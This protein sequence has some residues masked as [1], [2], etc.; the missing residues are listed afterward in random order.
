MSNSQGQLATAIEKA[1]FKLVGNVKEAAFD[2]SMQTCLRNNEHNLPQETMEALFSVYRNAVHTAFFDE[3]ETFM[4][5]IRVE[6][7]KFAEESA[8]ASKKTK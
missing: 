2:A 4:Q 6:L 7:D 8:V 3:V 1:T 5:S